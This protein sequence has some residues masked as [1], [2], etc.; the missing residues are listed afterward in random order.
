[1]HDHLR[2][3]SG[4]ISSSVSACGRLSARAMA[5]ARLRRRERRRAPS[6]ASPPDR[7]ARPSR[8]AIGWRCRAAAPGRRA[9]R[10]CRR[11]NPSAPAAAT[12]ARRA[13][14]APAIDAADVAGVDAGRAQI[15][16]TIHSP[17]RLS[18]AC[19]ARPGLRRARPAPSA[20]SLRSPSVSRK[21]FAQPLDQR[22]RRLVGDEMARELVRDM[23]RGR[24][25][26]REI[27]EHRA[28]LL[29]AGCRD[30]SCRSRS[31]GRARACAD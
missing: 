13:G 6:R 20:T 28:A 17:G 25:M 30:R 18:L 29:D 12:A 7:A 16:A 14:S 5:L 31:A 8:C 22:R 9:R 11:R 1:M 19:S 23:L 10:R 3:N 21:R 4:A 15:A 2:W 24:R 26:A 27:G